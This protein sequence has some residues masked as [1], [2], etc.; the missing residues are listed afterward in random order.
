MDTFCFFAAFWCGI[1]SPDGAMIDDV[2]CLGH[3]DLTYFLKYARKLTIFRARDKW[4]GFIPYSTP[5]TFHSWQTF[6]I[7]FFL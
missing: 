6:P 3:K 2:K 5:L 4:V 1:S 7:K